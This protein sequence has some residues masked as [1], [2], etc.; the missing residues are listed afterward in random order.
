MRESQYD[1][2]SQ[3]TG[4]FSVRR[5]AAAA[6]GAKCW[7]W[8]HLTVTQRNKLLF[9]G[10]HQ[11]KSG[12]EVYGPAIRKSVKPYTPI[13]VVVHT[14]SGPNP[15]FQSTRLGGSPSSRV[16]RPAHTDLLRGVHPSPRPRHSA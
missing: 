10:W 8:V 11:L 1:I 13:H 15:P 7:D 14:K 2:R 9:K 6:V 4:N 16:L 5:A 12:L 3:A